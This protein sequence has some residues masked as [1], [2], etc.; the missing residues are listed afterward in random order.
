MTVSLLYA[1]SYDMSL[2][3][4]DWCKP[5]VLLKPL[6]W[7]AFAA[8]VYKL[9]INHSTTV[10]KQESFFFNKAI[11]SPGIWGVLCSPLQQS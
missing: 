4:Q 7:W 5:V 8:K 1:Q 10:G 9:Y 3:L 11:V 2:A 6:K